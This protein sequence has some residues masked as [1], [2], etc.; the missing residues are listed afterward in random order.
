VNYGGT[1]A[2]TLSGSYV[3]QTT[4]DLFSGLVW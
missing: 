3:D 1:L 4:F 2:L